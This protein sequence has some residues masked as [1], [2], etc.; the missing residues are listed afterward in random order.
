MPIVNPPPP[1]RKGFRIT[2]P[3]VVIGMIVVGVLLAMLF[4]IPSHPYEASGRAKAKQD[5][6]SIVHA[7]EQYTTEYQQNPKLDPTVTDDLRDEAAG[8]PAAGL[9]LSNATLFNILRDIDR[10]PNA[11]HVQNPKH[12]VFFGAP[13]VSDA[14]RPKE[15]F[16]ETAGGGGVQ[17]AFYDP[18]GAQYNIVLDS[19]SDNVID[20]KDFYPDLSGADAPRISV[21]VFSLGKDRKL[22]INGDRKLNDG[23]NS[24]D[25]LTSWS[26]H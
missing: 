24:A 21:G 2:V 13:A 4:P 8:D 18:W 17:G 3:E 6:L 22:G 1:P 10:A 11:N 16:V 9:R 23:A 14:K 15:G 25:D 5:A 20:L 12:Q 26:G 19:N 7:V